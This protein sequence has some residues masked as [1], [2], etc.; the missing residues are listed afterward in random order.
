MQLIVCQ[1]NTLHFISDGANGN[2]VQAC[3]AKYVMQGESIDET[4]VKNVVGDLVNLARRVSS[5][6]AFINFLLSF[7]INSW[8]Y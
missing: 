5:T 1:W 7:F 2:L 4:T 3:S 6:F 8:I